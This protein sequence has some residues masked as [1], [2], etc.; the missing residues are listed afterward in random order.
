[1]VEMRCSA[2]A[3]PKESTIATLTVISQAQYKV[4]HI[5]EN[6]SGTYPNY[7][8]SPTE[9][10][11]LTGTIGTGVILLAKSYT[12]YTLDGAYTGNISTGT[13]L[14]DGSLVLRQ[15]YAIDR[16]ALTFE[17]NGGSTVSDQTNIPYNTPA[18]K[19]TDPTKTGYAFD[20]WFTESALQNPY[21]F[22]S[23]VTTDSTL[24]AK[25]APITTPYSIEHYLQSADLSYP[26]GASITESLTGMTDSLVSASSKTFT[27][28][29]LDT[30]IP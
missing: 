27:G 16:F 20:G 28:Y 19:P 17:E 23:G 8:A 4:E 24:Y 25:W 7:P 13:V 22:S 14:A 30:T 6:N 15:Y 2:N 21:N 9:I 3:C 26:S 18:T 1:M 29:T 12:G 10:E 5:L 11:T